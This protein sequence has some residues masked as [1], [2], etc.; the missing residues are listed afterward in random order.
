MEEIEISQDLIKYYAKKKGISFEQAEYE[1]NNTYG[2]EED[3]YVDFDESMFEFNSNYVSDPINPF[4]YS[5]NE[6]SLLKAA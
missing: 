6:V 4:K 3:K 1:L 5:F 2:Y